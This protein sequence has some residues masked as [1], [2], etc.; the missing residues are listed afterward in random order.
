MITHASEYFGRVS[1]LVARVEATLAAALGAAAD[2]CVA[3]LSSD[4][5]IHVFGSGHSSLVCQ[6][7]F[8]RAGG[9]LAI[10]WILAE[11]L[12]PLR[13]LRAGAMERVSGLAAAILDCEPIAAHD[14]LIVVSNS[15]RNPVPVEMAEE[16]RARG[17]R[18]VAITSL[19]HSRS[20]G[21]RAP[22]GSRLFEVADV[23]IDNL[24]RIGDAAM[25]LEVGGEIVAMGPT[26]TIVG[27][28]ILQAIMLEA[29]ARLATLQ[30][31]P[32]VFRSA[33]VEGGDDH[34]DGAFRQLG[35]RIP[36]LLAADVA[37][38]RSG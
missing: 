5:L 19:E 15:G 21:S 8:G 12:L 2:A 33:N 28:A 27:S 38:L 3:A 10:N 20:V 30:R 26:S 24:G 32:Q 11:D 13:G 29:V 14:V 16:G 4:R 36:S 9:L 7:V 37:R 23:V 35:G 25:T 31:P 1:D 34:N 18:T 17:L 22:S 6:D